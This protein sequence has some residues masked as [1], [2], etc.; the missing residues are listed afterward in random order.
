MA[1]QVLLICLQYSQ[2][3]KQRQETNNGRNKI[4]IEF[5]G[6]GQQ[7]S[8]NMFLVLLTHY[9]KRADKGDERYRIIGFRFKFDKMLFLASKNDSYYDVTSPC[10]NKRYD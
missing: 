5:L 1:E 3:Q 2:W 6:L 8:Y 9:Y 10:C 7:L 4:K